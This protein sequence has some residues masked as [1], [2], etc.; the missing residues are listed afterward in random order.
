MSTAVIGSLCSL[1]PVRLSAS[2]PL[3]RA[4]RHALGGVHT[5]CHLIHMYTCR[6]GSCPL[7]SP[8]DKR[9]ITMYL[10]H[11]I[12]KSGHPAL[13]LPRASVRR[14]ALQHDH[15]V[16]LHPRHAHPRVPAIHG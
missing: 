16:A 7:T 13:R 1:F 10:Y 8:P 3:A 5:P 11:A 9:T 15:G 12:V 14:S 6:R 4:C 2:T